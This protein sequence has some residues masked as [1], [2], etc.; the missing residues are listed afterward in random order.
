M[1]TRGSGW[2]EF[3][4]A[5]LLI[6][7]LSAAPLSAHGILGERMFIE[8][9]VT[10][11][12]NIKNEL[13]F[14]F[15]EF[16]V[17]PDGVWRQLAFSFEKELYPERLSITLETGR[18]YRHDNS[19]RLAGWDNL[20]AG[21]KFRAYA[22]EHHEFLLTPA[23][24]ITMPTSSQRVEEHD[25]ALTPKL[26]YGKGFGDASPGWLRPFAIQGDIGIKSSVQ[27]PSDHELLYDAVLMYSIPYLNHTVRKSDSGYALEHGLR[28]G[29]SAGAILG[30][31]FPYVEFNASHPLAGTPGSAISSLR[32]GILWM[33]KY[34]QV[35]FAADIPLQSEA[36][37]VRRHQGFCAS[38]DW[39]LDELVPAFN[40]TPWGKSHK[41]HD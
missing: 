24:F 30:N 25:T 41:H 3:G 7:I 16:M 20:D 40:W 32:P 11:D 33:G 35:S 8:P 17:Q 27:G 12:A 22:N 10:E 29:F 14:P 28:Q 39:F 1:A 9:L 36:A 34:V 23:L 15:A 5:T 19:Q 18:I 21:V 4:C 2:L 13:V 38:L 31:L 6:T 37:E 26:M